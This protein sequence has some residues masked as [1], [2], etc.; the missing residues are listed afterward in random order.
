MIDESAELTSSQVTALPQKLRHLIVLAQLDEDRFCEEFCASQKVKDV[1]TPRAWLKGDAGGDGTMHI[2]GRANKAKLAAFFQQKLD[3]E[4]FPL[5][6]LHAEFGE[7]KTQVDVL[8]ERRSQANLH[9]PIAHRL[10]RVTDRN[11]FDLCG[12]YLLYRHSFRDTGMIAREVLTLAPSAAAGYLMVRLYSYPV[13]STDPEVFCGSFFRYGHL[14]LAIVSYQDVNHE[15]RMRILHF[16][17]VMVPE[18]VYSG[19]MT[20]DSRD[21][22]EAVAVRCIAIRINTDPSYDSADGMRT[23][24]LGRDD[25]EI[26]EVLPHLDNSLDPNAFVLQTANKPRLLT[27]L[28]RDGPK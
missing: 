12:K 28:R 27:R 15:D 13:D 23:S 18:G 5:K 8:L 25:A 22:R 17:E 26:A 7:F 6:L 9:V 4:E 11:M 2:P 3:L 24:V 14:Y 16:P 1:R 20:S 21:H 10:G 19:L